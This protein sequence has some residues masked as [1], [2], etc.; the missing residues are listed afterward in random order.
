VARVSDGVVHIYP[1]KDL[2]EHVTDGGDCPCG[3]TTEPVERADGNIG[4]VIV[5]HALDGREHSER[6]HNKTDCPCCSTQAA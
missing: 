2:I 4:Y 1:V 6:N 5:H 3:P